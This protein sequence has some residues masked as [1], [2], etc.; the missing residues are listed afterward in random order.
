[1]SWKV[2]SLGGMASTLTIAN[3]IIPYLEELGY[4]AVYTHEANSKGT[5]TITINGVAY[6]C[7]LHIANTTS[8]STY[9]MVNADTNEIV[10]GQTGRSVGSSSQLCYIASLALLRGTATKTGEVG[11]FPVRADIGANNITNW[12]GKFDDTA[13]QIYLQKAVFPK[14]EYATDRIYNEI[15]FVA[16]NIY[17]GTAS[18]T[19]GA[20]VAVGNDTFVCINGCMY[21]KL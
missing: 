2:Y 13:E 10:I 3:T 1:M 6:L 19:P 14:Y 7:H 5:I 20:T 16:D 4:S 9:L 18:Y 11:L 15:P 21:A 8:Y 12:W 17:W